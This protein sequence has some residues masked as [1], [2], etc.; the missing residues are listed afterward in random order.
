MKL[1]SYLSH[2]RA[3]Y[4]TVKNGAIVDLG[5]RMGSRYP[6]LK[7]LLQN[8]GIS[9]ARTLAETAPPDLGLEE[10]RFLPPVPD[11]EKYLCIGVNYGERNAEYRDGSVRPKYPSVFLRTPDSLVGHGEAI[12]RPPESNQL[13]YEGEIAIVIGKEG[14]RIAEDA[15]ASHI[16]GLT[17]MNE[18]TVRDWLRHGKFNVT[19]GKNFVHSGAMGPWIVTV[20]EIPGYDNLRVETRVN[21]ELRQSDTTANLIFPFCYLISYLSTCML[22]KPGDVIS[23]GTPNGAGARLDPPIYLRPGDVVEVQVPAVGTLRNTVEDE[24]RYPA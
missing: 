12:L 22:L 13:D 21:G 5:L 23:T 2:G 10:I 1:I 17:I 3:S 6:T 11:A 18:G 24:K 7:A 19:Q 20:D 15:A 9:A 16:A 8:D 14:R 4:G